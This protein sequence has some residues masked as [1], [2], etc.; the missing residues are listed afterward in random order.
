LLSEQ[1]TQDMRIQDIV[2]LIESEELDDVVLCAHSAGGIVATG[3]AERI[4]ERIASVVMLDAVV[5][6]NGESLFEILATAEGITS[7]QR[8]AKSAEGNGW[9]M[10]SERLNAA[11]FGVTDPNDA[12]WVM[13]RLTDDSARAHAHRLVVTDG[14]A[15]VGNRIYVRMTGFPLAGLDLV[16]DRL[17]TDNSWTMHRW[18]VGHNAMITHPERVA[19]LIADA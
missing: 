8:R 13:R 5:P 17:A 3:V 9:R 16:Y 10:R 14:L 18:D 19:K 6:H 7:E 11:M 2:G 12:A 4:A 1:V 15:R